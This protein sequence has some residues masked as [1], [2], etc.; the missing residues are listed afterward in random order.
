VKSFTPAPPLPR[1]RLLLRLLLLPP[2][3]LLLLLLLLLQ[4]ILL[5]TSIV[6]HAL[7][8]GRRNHESRAH[9]QR[10]HAPAQPRTFNPC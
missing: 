10:R 1:P 4:E 2:L 9:T 6:R 7:C 3:L 8:A 5:A